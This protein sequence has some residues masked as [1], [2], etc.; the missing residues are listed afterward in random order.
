[1]IFVPSFW[2]ALQTIVVPHAVTFDIIGVPPG[3]VIRISMV[4]ALFS[5]ILMHLIGF[6]D[7]IRQGCG[8]KAVVRATV[9][10]HGDAAQD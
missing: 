9:E 10:S 6:H 1:M 5:G 4:M 2:G 3:C 8:G 7:L